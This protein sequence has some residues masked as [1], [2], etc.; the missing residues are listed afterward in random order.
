MYPFIPEGLA[1][2]RTQGQGLASADEGAGLLSAS[3]LANDCA[4][5]IFYLFHF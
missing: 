2:G 5:T 4:T 3:A 1:P